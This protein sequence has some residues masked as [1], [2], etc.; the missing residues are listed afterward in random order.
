MPLIEVLVYRV[1]SWVDPGA[2]PCYLFPYT[3]YVAPLFLVPQ[4]IHLDNHLLL[5]RPLHWNGDHLLDLLDAVDR[6]N[7]EVLG[8]LDL[9]RAFDAVDHDILLE[10][11]RVTL[12]VKRSPRMVSVLPPR[13]LSACSLWQQ[14]LLA[15]QHLLWCTPRIGPPFHHLHHWFGTD[16]H[17]SRIVTDDSQIYG[18]CRPATTATVVWHH[19]VCEHHIQF[20]DIKSASTQCQQNGGDVVCIY[21][22]TSATSQLSIVRRLHHW[23]M[24][25]IFLAIDVHQ[26]HSC[27]KS[28]HT[29]LQLLP[30]FTWK[31]LTYHT[32]NSGSC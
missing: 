6:G 5:V 17:G 12:G 27:C 3:H 21:S 18:F 11:L 25:P 22:C 9:S 8:L 24:P 31:L 30:F 14:V 32:R 7:S 10:K 1:L 19:R 23:F 4:E 2:M 16:H 26:H 28:R 13:S 20:D 29:D 15:C